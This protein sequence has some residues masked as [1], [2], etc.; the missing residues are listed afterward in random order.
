M[1]A[2]ALLRMPSD[3]IGRRWQLLQQLATNAAAYIRCITVM[4]L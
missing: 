2:T 3:G 1:S 4:H